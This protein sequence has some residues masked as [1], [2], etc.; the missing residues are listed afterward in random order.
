[1][2]INKAREMSTEGNYTHIKKM[3]NPNFMGEWS[4]PGGKDV[5]LTIKGFGEQEGWSK[6]KN[7]KVKLPVIIWAEEYDWAKPLKPNSTN[8]DTL[9]SVTEEKAQERM[10]GKIVQIGIIEGV[11]F[12]KKQ[13]ALRIRNVKSSKLA[14]DY[15]DFVKS[16]PTCKSR[17]EI[18]TLM[19]KYALFR[20]F[21]LDVQNQIKAKWN[22]VSV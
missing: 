16:I 12:G 17:E 3:L 11:F 4:L 18:S 10:I 2:D 14:Q 22:L 1:M 9:I 5:A 6:D 20:P 21:S 15:D 19:N 7:K 8:I 13:G